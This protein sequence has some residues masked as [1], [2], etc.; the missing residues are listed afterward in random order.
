MF[1]L[2][3]TWS[4]VVDFMSIL[5]PGATEGPQIDVKVLQI[6]NLAR[7]GLRRQKVATFGRPPKIAPP[8][9]AP[10]DH[11]LAGKVSL[12]PQKVWGLG[13]SVFK[14][15]PFVLEGTFRHFSH[16][17]RNVALFAE[18]GHF[19]IFRCFPLSYT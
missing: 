11:F 16:F 7:F 14:K 17:S 8:E 3:K 10:I 6:A 18:I 19:L 1:E 12:S 15:G 13:K 4:Q 2:L 5:S 9:G